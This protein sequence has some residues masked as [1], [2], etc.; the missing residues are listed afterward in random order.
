MNKNHKITKNLLSNAVRQCEGVDILH[1]DPL[2]A[3]QQV[4][5]LWSK[6]R[7]N[8]STSIWNHWDKILLFE[9]RNTATVSVQL[10]V[11]RD[12]GT[13]ASGVVRIHLRGPLDDAALARLSIHIPGN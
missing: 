6:M 3:A 12:D 9:G 5:E 11:R 4:R 7:K 2:A 10:Y 13:P 8:G 1:D